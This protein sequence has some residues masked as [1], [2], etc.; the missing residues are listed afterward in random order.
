MLNARNI[1]VT[2]QYKHTRFSSV[3]E[4]AATKKPTK[5][6]Q[7]I[8]AN[9]LHNSKSFKDE[10]STILISIFSGIETS[11]INSSP[12][13]FD[14]LLAFGFCSAIMY[15][16]Y[17]FVIALISSHSPVDKIPLYMPP[18]IRGDI[19]KCILSLIPFTRV[20]KAERIDS[21]SILLLTWT[22]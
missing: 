18:F 16:D 1:P 7:K 9:K 21:H 3:F 12:I 15:N 20:V 2:D 8:D 4:I 6:L 10:A 11:T 14:S 22:I 17:I 13:G 5:K 19:I